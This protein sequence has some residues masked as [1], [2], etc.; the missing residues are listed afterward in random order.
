MDP[1]LTALVLNSVPLAPLDLT[2]HSRSGESTLEPWTGKER[3]EEVSKMPWAPAWVRTGTR[4][5]YVYL[6]P[7]QLKF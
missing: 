4:R 1:L 7:V 3:E 2:T 6:Y 5:D